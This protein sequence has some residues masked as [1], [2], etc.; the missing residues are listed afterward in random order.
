MLCCQ[1]KSQADSVFGGDYSTLDR[2]DTGS[3]HSDSKVRSVDG[4]NSEIEYGD[5]FDDAIKQVY[6][7]CIEM[8]WRNGNDSSY[9]ITCTNFLF[10]EN[11]RMVN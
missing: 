6:D 8:W 3:T 11:N 9:F 2:L 5:T 4:T 7:S 10:Y 1:A